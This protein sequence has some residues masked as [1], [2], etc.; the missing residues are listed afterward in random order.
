MLHIFGFGATYETCFALPANGRVRH[1]W[2]KRIDV[3]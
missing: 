1:D 3:L 2:R